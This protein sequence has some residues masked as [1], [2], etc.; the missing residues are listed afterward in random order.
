[1]HRWGGGAEDPLI[2]SGRGNGFV[3]PRSGRAVGSRMQ[4]LGLS[5]LRSR[6]IRGARSRSGSARKSEGSGSGAAAGCDE[7]TGP[8]KSTLLRPGFCVALFFAKSSCH[9]EY[10]AA[11]REGLSKNGDMELRFQGGHSIPVHSLKLRLASSVL[12]DML[13]DVLDD[14]IAS[15]AAKRRKTAE[16]GSTAVQDMPYVK[17][18][19]HE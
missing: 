16:G 2:R 17:V 7:M 3:F 10:A 5:R 15:A 4:E 18:S 9:M 1:M 11:L 12:N 8:L 6:H 13:T 14:Q 19:R